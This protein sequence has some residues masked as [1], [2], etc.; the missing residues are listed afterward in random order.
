MNIAY[1]DNVDILSEMRTAG[2][3]FLKF[4]ARK[5]VLHFIIR[6]EQVERMYGFRH[7]LGYDLQ[8]VDEVVIIFQRRPGA[9]TRLTRSPTLHEPLR[10]LFRDVI[11]PNTRI[12]FVNIGDL[13]PELV[14]MPPETSP[15][16]VVAR[17]PAYFAKQK[18]SANKNPVAGKCRLFTLDEYRTH[19]SAEQFELET[20]A[21]HTTSD[22]N[23]LMPSNAVPPLIP[24]PP[25]FADVVYPDFV[26]DD[27]TDDSDFSDNDMD[28]GDLQDIGSVMFGD[29]FG[30]HDMHSSDFV[31]EPPAG[32]WPD[33]WPELS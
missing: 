4:Y 29:F 14:G 27:M 3:Q 9:P 19:V 23:P 20:V 15:D 21:W 7:R 32:G 13:Y 11:T 1:A 30:T 10:R 26:D 8:G 17:F 28:L 6:P 31:D 12:S 16:D 18:R 33:D 5:L 25:L 24:L 2:F 22:D